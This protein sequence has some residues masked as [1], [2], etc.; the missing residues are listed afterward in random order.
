MQIKSRSNTITA[1]KT[2]L[3]I[4]SIRF[5]SLQSSDESKNAMHINR[6]EYKSSIGSIISIEYFV[7]SVNITIANFINIDKTGNHHPRNKFFYSLFHGI[8]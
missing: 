4:S 6:L 3:I 7:L 1:A 2:Y 5:L 8:Y